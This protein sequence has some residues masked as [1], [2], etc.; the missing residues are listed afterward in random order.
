MFLHIRSIKLFLIVVFIS[1]TPLVQALDTLKL[2]RNW[3]DKR[4]GQDLYYW[5][6]ESNSVDFEAIEQL[7]TAKFKTHFP[8]KEILIGFDPYNYWLYVPVKNMEN[9]P[10]KYFLTLGNPN[11]DEVHVYFT[12]PEDT[13]NFNPV[14]D[15]YSYPQTSFS[16]RNFSFPLMVPARSD[17]ALWIHIM[18]QQEPVLLTAYLSSESFF[19]KR[20]KNDFLYLGM[21]TG[22]FF[23]FLLFIIC[24]YQFYKNR[25]FLYYLGINLVIFL[26]YIS[27]TGIGFQMFWPDYP[28]IQKLMPTLVAFLFMFITNIFLKKYYTT[29]IHYPRFNRVFNMVNVFLVIIFLTNNIL[30]FQPSFIRL[31]FRITFYILNLIYVLYGIVFLI[32]ILFTWIKLKRKDVLWAF[33][34]PFLHV[35]KCVLFLF[36][37]AKVY[38]VLFPGANLYDLNIVRTHVFLPNIFFFI[39]YSQVI[40]VSIFLANYFKKVNLEYNMS[41][42]R[43]TVLQ[44]TSINAMID[45]QE[46]ERKLLKS[47]MDHRI[48]ED[49]LELK[50]ITNDAFMA[51]NDTL[52]KMELQSGLSEIDQILKDLENLSSDVL[53]MEVEQ[54]AIHSAVKNVFE[55]MA[56]TAQLDFHYHENIHPFATLTN[57]QKSNVYRIAQELATNI[58][59]HAQADKV[60]VD[61]EIQP[62]QLYMRVAD[63]GKGFDSVKAFKGKGIGL[64][65]MESRVKGLSGIFKISGT[66]LGTVVEMTIPL[67]T[68]DKV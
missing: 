53:P 45:G 41:N 38:K 12:T 67:Q 1:Q 60:E 51:T 24:L 11:T 17:C 64:S 42:K 43:L 15:N 8:M 5:R 57:L 18:A 19:Y 52:T 10:F 61:V 33:I 58:L 28:F 62:K 48:K 49:L 2:D 65:N 47:E 31:P 6:D 59:K 37:N 50:K 55:R 32:L 20:A 3:K 35:V 9:Q 56:E 68:N 44:R 34:G 16:A 21:F 46:K 39:D 22:I 7:K 63:N 29:T 36:L 14:G 25:I 23:L 66:S 40:I 27:E 30:S 4:I 13:F 54:M 26:Y